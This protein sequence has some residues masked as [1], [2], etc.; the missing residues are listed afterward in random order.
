MHFSYLPGQGR[1]HAHKY[2]VASYLKGEPIMHHSILQRWLYFLEYIFEKV[3]P[4]HCPGTQFF[5]AFKT[6]NT[7]LHKIRSTRIAQV[8]YLEFYIQTQQS[9]FETFD[10]PFSSFEE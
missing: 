6:L 10:L 3:K 1:M 9:K 4:R 2:S 5:L 7:G 8:D